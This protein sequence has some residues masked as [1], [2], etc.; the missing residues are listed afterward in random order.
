MRIGSRAQNGCIFSPEFEVV[1]TA[2][3]RRAW[4][5]NNALSECSTRGSQVAK[6]SRNLHLD[7][8]AVMS[9]PYPQKSF[10]LDVPVTSPPSTSSSKILS[11]PVLAPAV[12]LYTRF[13]EW[14]ASLGL[15]SPGTM[16]NL[17]KDIKCKYS[18]KFPT[19]YP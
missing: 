12:G 8:V 2:L 6:G 13:A 7:L 3:C 1:L 14:R 10:S 16:E 15:P 19:R 11:H 9:V 5:V 18:S 17:T 4:N